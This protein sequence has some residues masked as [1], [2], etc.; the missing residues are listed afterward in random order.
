M[1]E[2]QKP[3]RRHWLRRRPDLAILKAVVVRY[4]MHEALAWILD[5]L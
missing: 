2:N 4:L 5:V 3:D 1:T